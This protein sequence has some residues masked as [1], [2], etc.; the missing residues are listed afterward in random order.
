MDRDCT[1]TFDGANGSAPVAGVLQF[2]GALYG[3]TSTGGPNNS[4][5]TVYEVTF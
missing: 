1:V 4:F 2:K 3:T 5:G